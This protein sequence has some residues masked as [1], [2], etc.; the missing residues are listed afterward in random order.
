VPAD[1]L[2]KID[3]TAPPKTVLRPVP[4]SMQSSAFSGLQ[5]TTQ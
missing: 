2:R 5:E 1:E 4:K 3:R